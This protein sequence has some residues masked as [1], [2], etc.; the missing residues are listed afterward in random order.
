MKYFLER[1]RYKK[2]DFVNIF[3]QIGA[4]VKPNEKLFKFND[5]Q[6][7]VLNLKTKPSIEFLETTSIRKNSE[8]IS[9]KIKEE[10]I[11]GF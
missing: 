3:K 5:F 11:K 8:S 6:V 7:P 2:D 9:R 10:V 4:Q 1:L